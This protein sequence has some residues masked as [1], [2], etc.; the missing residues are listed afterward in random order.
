MFVISGLG[1]VYPTRYRS[2]LLLSYAVFEID[3]LET[4]TILR[5]LSVV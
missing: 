3:R 2:D 1:K 5:Q 4:Y